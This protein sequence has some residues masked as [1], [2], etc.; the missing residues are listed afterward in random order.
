MDIVLENDQKDC[1]EKMY[2]AVT[3]MKR[4]RKDKIDIEVFCW[5]KWK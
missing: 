3:R 4:N 1:K 2:K 5:E